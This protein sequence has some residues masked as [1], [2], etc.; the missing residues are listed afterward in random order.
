M[1]NKKSN[2]PNAQL[3]T[4]DE[5]FSAVTVGLLNE[6]RKKADRRP[7]TVTELTQRIDDYFRFCADHQMRPG[8]EQLA[9]CLG[10]SRQMYWRW[11]AGEKGAEWQRICCQA[12]Q[13]VLAFLESASLS[14][15]LNPATGI[16]LLKNW[17]NYTDS[18]AITAIPEKELPTLNDIKKWLPDVD[19]NTDT[20]DGDSID[21][22]I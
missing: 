13:V 6:I 21:D 22:F 9:L 20:V 12:R 15:H 19:S 17:A 14:G 11:C 5:D 8:I 1:S 2:L 16:F 3:S 4:I 10:V 18:V 7:E